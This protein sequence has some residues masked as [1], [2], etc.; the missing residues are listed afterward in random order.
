MLTGLINKVIGTRHERERR[1][2]QP[3]IDLI[4][5]QG[6]KLQGLSDDE[7]R[8]KTVAFQATLAERTGALEARVAELRAAKRLASDPAERDRIDAELTGPDGR[9]GVEGEL[10]QAVAD[11]LDDLLPEAFATVREACRRL[12][13]TTVSVTGTSPGPGY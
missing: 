5:E 1:R 11:A 3:L 4:D 12:I 7:L 2:M 10:R 8:G 13:G 6:E 9:G